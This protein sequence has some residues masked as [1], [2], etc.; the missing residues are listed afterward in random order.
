M[1]LSVD[2]GEDEAGRSQVCALLMELCAR[3]PGGLPWSS[4]FG[5]ANLGEFAVRSL[6]ERFP[7][8]RLDCATD[9][10]EW[11]PN[12]VGRALRRLPVAVAR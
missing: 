11:Q 7:N 6:V 10:L 3:L 1:E 4:A 8:L 12:I 9:E 5:P 2:N